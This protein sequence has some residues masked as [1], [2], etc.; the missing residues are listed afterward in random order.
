LAADAHFLIESFEPGYLDAIGLGYEALREINPGIIVVSITPFG[1]RGPKAHWPATDL[2]TYASAV[3][4]ILTGDSDRA[5]VRVAVPQAFLHAS[6]DGAAGALIAHFARV[7][8]GQGQHVDVSAQTSAMMACQSFVLSGAWG[9]VGLERSAGGL[10]LGPLEIK[11]VHAA[12]DGHVSVTFL[13]GTALG[14]FARRLMEQLYEEGF[15]DEATR[16]KDWLNYTTLLLTGQEPIPELF[17]CNAAIAAWCAAHTKQELFEMAM[18][19]H[20]LIVPVSTTED[21]VQSPQLAAR[22]FWTGVSQPGMDAPVIYPGPFAK[23]SE[24]PLQYRLPPPAIGQHNA[25]ILG[26]LGL[27]PSSQRALYAQGV[28]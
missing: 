6:A 21:V 4:L 24:T 16:D 19:K 18:E 11:F 26:A 15:V 13:F 5:P 12:K 28:I 8:D 17:R 14:P 1:Q 20:L 3:S 23:F 22:D 2:T 10:R 9:D 27:E 7:A 25:E